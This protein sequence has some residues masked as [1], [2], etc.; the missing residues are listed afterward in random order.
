MFTLKIPNEKLKKASDL[1]ND[2]LWNHLSVIKKE[3]YFSHTKLT[4]KQVYDQIKAH[5]EKGQAI[6]VRLYKP[7]WWR[8]KAIAYTKGKNVIFINQYKLNERSATEYANTLVHEYLH[9]VGFGHGNNNPKGKEQ[10]V[11]YRVGQ[12]AE[13]YASLFK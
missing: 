12:L 7:F 9:I 4:S 8:S 13:D 11:P 2:F 3:P 10:S 5:L 6:E 1:A